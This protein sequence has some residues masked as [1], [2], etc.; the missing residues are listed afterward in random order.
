MN[1]F[2]VILGLYFTFLLLMFLRCEKVT[3]ISELAKNTDKI[4]VIFYDESGNEASFIDITDKKEIRKFSS[5]ISE[6]ETPLYKCRID[7]RLIFFL[8]EESARGNY[9]S[10]DMDF[11]L[12]DDCHHV[13]YEYSGRLQTKKMTDKGIDYLRSL[14]ANYNK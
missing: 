3:E 11:N 8:N 2:R 7:G 6:M 9:N 10:V 13:A 1:L 14:K 12:E 5:Y 4:Q